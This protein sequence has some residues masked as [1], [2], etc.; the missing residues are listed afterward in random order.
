[1]KVNQT[2]SSLNFSGGIHSVSYK[3]RQLTELT[4]PQP[5]RIIYFTEDAAPSHITQQFPCFNARRLIEKECR[6][7]RKDYK[8]FQNNFSNTQA[9][10]ALNW[11]KNETTQIS[12]PLKDKAL[13]L[14]A[15]LAETELK[16]KVQRNLLKQV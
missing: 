15:E 5:R 4:Q 8:T 13:A 7:E 9:L 2:E 1:M 16:E 10:S 3:E 11:L 14:L 12:H 6:P